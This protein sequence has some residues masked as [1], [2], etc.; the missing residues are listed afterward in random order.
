MRNSCFPFRTSW[1][2]LGYLL[3][4]VSII[5]NYLPQTRCLNIFKLGPRAALQG[6]PRDPCALWGKPGDPWALWGDPTPHR[7]TSPEER[8]YTVV[9]PTHCHLAHT[10]YTTTLLLLSGTSHFLWLCATS[11]TCP[12]LRPQVFP[13]CK[14]KAAVIPLTPNIY[15]PHGR[16]TEHIVSEAPRTALTTIQPLDVSLLHQLSMLETAAYR[17]MES[18]IYTAPQWTLSEH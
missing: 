12:S 15:A 17:G 10:S 8:N 2:S 9:G 1:K 5:A 4:V 14:H 16:Y 7:R 6:R 13:A 18:N 3:N 11:K